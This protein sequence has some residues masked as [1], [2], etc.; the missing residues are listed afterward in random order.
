MADDLPTLE[1]SCAGPA[2]AAAIKS[3]NMA[4]FMRNRGVIP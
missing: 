1:G 4:A 2:Y 3:R